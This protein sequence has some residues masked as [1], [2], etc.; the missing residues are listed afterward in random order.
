MF[1]LTDPNG[2]QTIGY[3][4][5][6]SSGLLLAMD[7]HNLNTGF[8]ASAPSGAVFDA[9]SFG[10][11]SL[12]GPSEGDQ[13]ND[14]GHVYVSSPAI[15]TWTWTFAQSNENPGA[16]AGELV[17]FLSATGV[18]TPTYIQG[19]VNDTNTTTTTITLAC[20]PT[21]AGHTWAIMA[22]IANT[23]VTAIALTDTAGNT[24]VAADGPTTVTSYSKVKTFYV[25]TVVNSATTITATYTGQSGTHRHQ[26][27]LL[28]FDGIDQTTPV[29]Q[30]VLTNATEDGSG[31]F[32]SGS[33]TNTYAYDALVGLMNCN[34]VCS[35]VASLGSGYNIGR[36]DTQGKAYAEWKLVSATGSYT[37]GAL[38]A[39]IG[40]NSGAA[41][42]TL[43]G[44]QPAAGGATAGVMSLLGVGH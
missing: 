4:P 34:S 5:G 9:I 36:E 11:Q 24:F 38:D 42:I 7:I 6:M 1:T 19:C 26:L 13:N 30:H 8:N 43:K 18:T 29:D 44:V 35:N 41:L 31:N 33:V 27:I 3:Q 14:W 22:S 28:E 32:A 17:S 16:Y 40:G 20:T 12:D 2:Y 23:A 25:T 21:G 37:A 39:G 15:A 10:G